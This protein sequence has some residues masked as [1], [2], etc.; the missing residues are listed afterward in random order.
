MKRALDMFIFPRAE[1]NGLC[2]FMLPNLSPRN[3]GAV[4]WYMK[5]SGFAAFKV[6][7]FLLHANYNATFVRIGGANAPAFLDNNILGI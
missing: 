6:Y 2:P 4:S 5:K 3:C 1:Q 7:K